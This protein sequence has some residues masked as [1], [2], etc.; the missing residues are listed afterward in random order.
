MI[1]DNLERTKEFYTNLFGWK[2]KKMSGIGQR[3]YWTFSTTSSKK[4]KKSDGDEQR[5]VSGEMIKRQMPQEPI[6]IYVGVSSVT[7]L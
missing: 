3:D 4:D 7:E 2:I 1:S 5:T 6:M